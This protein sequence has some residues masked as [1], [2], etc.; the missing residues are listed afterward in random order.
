MT[1]LAP[2]A[3]DELK[4]RAPQAA[5]L[6]R[7]LANPNRLLILCHIAQEERSVGQ[8]EVDL[9]IRQPALSQQLAE[10]RQ[11]GLVKTRRQ[12]RS[13]YYSI[14]DERAEAVMVML[15]EIFCSDGTAAAGRTRATPTAATPRQR[16]DTAQFARIGPAAR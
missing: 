9:G 10:L 14:A 11:F 2:T 15:H 1:D 3:M 4:A 13:I 12:S 16:G 5:E 7:Q 6:L 8:L